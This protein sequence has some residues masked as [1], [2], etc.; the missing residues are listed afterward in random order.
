MKR[1]GC[2]SRWL[3]AAFVWVVLAPPAFGLDPRLSLRQYLH[4]SWTQTDG[5][6]IPGVNALAQTPDG[7]LWLG[8]N[9]GLL[10]FDGLKFSTPA[11]SEHAPGE[12]IR[13]LAVSH[14]GGLW[15]GTP[16]GVSLWD[17]QTL[18]RPAG[19]NLPTGAAAALLE[20][21]EGRLWFSSAVSGTPTFVVLD[22]RNPHPPLVTGGGVPTEAVSITE[23]T[24]GAIWVASGGEIYTCSVSGRTYACTAAA[25]PP[26]SWNQHRVVLKAVLHDRDGNLWLGTMGQGL[27][28]VRGGTTEHFTERDGLSGDAVAALFEDRE[29]DIWAATINGIDR[30]RDPRVARWTNVQGL[31]GNVITAVRAT[32]N[33]DLLAGTLGGGLDRLGRAGISHSRAFSGASRTDV[34]SLF[35]DTRGTLWLGTTRG[36]GTLQGNAFHVMRSEN[37][38]P[39]ERVFAFA[40]DQD[41]TLWLADADRGLAS[42][43]GNTIVPRH[44]P[45]VDD[46]GIHQLAIDRAGNLWIGYVAGGVAVI[47]GSTARRY[48]AADGLAPGCV[49]ALFEDRSGA[50]WVGTTRGMSRFRQGVWTTWSAENGLPPGGVQAFAQDDQGTLWLVTRAGFAPVSLTALGP[51]RNGRPGGAKP[52]QLA[53][54]FYGPNDG[55]RMPEI[56]GIANP[57]ITTSGDGRIWL[58]TSDGL[59]VFDPKFIRRNQPL[60]PMAIDQVLNDGKLQ[61][62]ARIGPHIRGRSIEIDYTALSLAVP[63]A[64]RFRYRLDPLD[65]NWVDA[66]T[67]R[68][69]AYAELSPGRYRFLVTARGEDG[70]WNPNPASI[71]FTVDPRFYQTWPFAGMCLCGIVLLAYAAHKWRMRLMRTRFQIVLRERSRLTRELH[72]TLLQG[73]AGVVFQLEAATRQMDTQPDASRARIARALEQADQALREARQAL[74]SMRMPELENNTLPEALKRAAE[75]IAGGSS[76]RFHMEVTGHTRELPYDVQAN[77]FVIARE[78]VNNAVAHAGAGRITITMD[79]GADEV[80]LVVKDDGRGFDLDQPCRSDHW[81]LAGMRE[82]A[83]HIGAKLTIRSAPGKGTEV[84]AV[85]GKPGRKRIAAD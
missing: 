1:R 10:R 27:F 14:L 44:F 42:V 69:I 70:F 64:L 35:E 16:R 80:T 45:G 62:P 4:K 76:A 74:S 22:T 63:E 49:Q 8:T 3:C 68:E 12:S 78:A 38:W 61:A 67:R 39:Y 24:N 85:T 43:R 34:L 82:R 66:G 60:P 71:E 75:S 48:R 23:D 26:V 59:A 32:R 28:L 2:A 79:Y 19:F 36:A 46:H 21:R 31:S 65:S 18:S 25:M 54:V 51:I 81:G 57:R 58:A 53:L 17:H 52:D 83:H 84:E 6:Q 37:G 29:G 30:F 73:F 41:G 33:G 15:I 5:A 40:Q 50:V 9:R 20:D 11:A 7:Y 56:A 77:L 47:G 13:A 72:D 55:V